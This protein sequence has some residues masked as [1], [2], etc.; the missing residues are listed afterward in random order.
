MKKLLLI[1]PIVSLASL[2]HADF[3]TDFKQKYQEAKEAFGTPATRQDTEN[4]YRSTDAAT[5]DDAITAFLKK[6]GL[7]SSSDEAESSYSTVKKSNAAAKEFAQ[8]AIRSQNP[9][10]KKQAEGLLKTAE[11]NLVT[12]QTQE[13][14]MLDTIARERAEIQKLQEQLSG[15]QSQGSVLD[16]LMSLKK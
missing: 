9:S 10:K 15:S 13:K 2:A 16:W 3:I 4:Q 7:G 12:L 8:E 1:L 5:K 6:L 14:E 11:Q